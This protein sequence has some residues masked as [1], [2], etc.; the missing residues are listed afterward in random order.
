MVHE[1]RDDVTDSSLCEASHEAANRTLERTGQ[2]WAAHRQHAR[3]AVN[4]C[5]DFVVS[6]AAKQN[7]PIFRKVFGNRFAVDLFGR[8]EVFSFKVAKF[9]LKPF[10]VLGEKVNTLFE[11]GDVLPENSSTTTLGDDLVKLSKD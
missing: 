10:I 1:L 4:L 5:L 3:G 9:F 6:D 2:Y 8:V 7:S 11:Q